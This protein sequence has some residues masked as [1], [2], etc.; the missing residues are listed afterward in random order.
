V[1]LLLIH[2][3]TRRGV[4][5]IIGGA[6][7]VL[8]MIIGY[9][10]Y[11]MSN[12][13]VNEFQSIL[14]DMRKLDVDREQE[15]LYIKTISPS[16]TGLSADIVND[17]PNIINIIYTCYRDISDPT[18]PYHYTSLGG[19]GI[20]I[21]PS[22]SKPIPIDIP[23]Y[24]S[25]GSYSIR[26]ISD[27]GKAY[28]SSWPVTG[29]EGGEKTYITGE[30]SDVIG[31]FLPTYLSFQ[32]ALRDKITQPGPDPYR[33]FNFNWNGN[34]ACKTGDD[35]LAFRLK[36]TWYGK[37]PITLGKNTALFMSS[38]KDTGGPSYAFF[39]VYYNKATDTISGYD[40]NTSPIS[41]RYE[42][43]KTLYFAAPLNDIFGS[44]E[45]EGANL[46]SD[47]RPYS[48]ALGIY[49]NRHVYS[50][51][52]PLVALYTQ[53]MIPQRYP[54][55]LSVNPS[56]SGI[57]NPSGLVQWSAGN[58]YIIANANEGYAFSDWTSSSNIY[59]NQPNSYDT[60]ATFN[61]DITGGTITANF[62]LSSTLH[63]FI[64]SGPP[65][66]PANTPF[67]VTVS[68]RYSNGDIISDYA[69]KIRFTSSDGQAV[70]PIDYTFK[71]GDSGSHPFQITLK[72]IGPQTIT[73][74]DTTTALSA[75]YSI[76]VT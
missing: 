25:Y 75:T 39:L 63:H 49:D 66:S 56:G 29:L 13:S 42:E 46:H 5:S 9:A 12:Q 31:K 35:C 6:F 62:V 71:S 45:F 36:V 15:H 37:S 26:L 22:A 8:I 28:T 40:P 68:A 54:I 23:G 52:F 60:I 43:T 72:T 3:K 32:W 18:D 59:I 24:S 33:I 20:W 27:R 64:I 74:T 53:D 70:L 47:E 76:L 1:L 7:L 50:Q 41:F 67:D 10:F 38:I 44:L 55:T 51:S 2:G 34:W 21:D 14:S 48:V 57:T 11:V 19:D 58:N 16:S 61:G 73:V 69:G 30:I 4:G 65:N 17:G